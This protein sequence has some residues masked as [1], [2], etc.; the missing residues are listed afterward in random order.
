MRTKSIHF[1][2]PQ[3]HEVSGSE[4]S[5]TWRNLDSQTLFIPPSL[6]NHGVDELFEPMIDMGRETMSLPFE[7]KMKYWQGNQG[8][9]FG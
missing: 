3:P 8:A 4:Y 1:G 5:C 6:K 2:K 9:S 7:E